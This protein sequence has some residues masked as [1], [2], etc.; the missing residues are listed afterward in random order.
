MTREQIFDI[1]KLSRDD[2]EGLLA[3]LA[4]RM[5]RQSPGH[6]V[7]ADALVAPAN[8]SNEAQLLGRFL[9]SLSEI[10]RAVLLMYLDDLSN[11]EISEAMGVS[12]GAIRTR[13]SRIRD[14]LE[15]WE[16]GDGES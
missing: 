15:T 8:F 4:T 9:A 12:N 7:A 10:D 16:T 5:K 14:Q 3:C 1:S 2:R 6:R 11:K 13:I